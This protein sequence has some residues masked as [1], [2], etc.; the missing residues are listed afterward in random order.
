MAEEQTVEPSVFERHL[1]TGIQLTLVM[2]LGWAGLKLVDLGENTAVL[3]ERLVYQG[4][5]ISSLRRELREWS[6]VYYLKAD[7]ARELSQIKDNV[8]DLDRRVSKLEGEKR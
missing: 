8:S 1:Q 4:E 7:A 2:L 5:Q 3:Q 6:N